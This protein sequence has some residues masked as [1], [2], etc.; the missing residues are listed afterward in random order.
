MIVQAWILA[1]DLEGVEGVNEAIALSSIKRRHQRKHATLETSILSPKK[2]K[3]TMN[4]PRPSE[5]CSLS[6]AS[7]LALFVGALQGIAGMSE[8]IDVPTV[9]LDARLATVYLAMF[10]LTSTFVMGIFTITYGTFCKLYAGGK[11]ARVFFVDSF[12]LA[13]VW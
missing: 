9:Q 12:L 3:P 6:T 7:L 11:Q 1:V 4:I 2:F 8:V 5:S 13:L 10:C